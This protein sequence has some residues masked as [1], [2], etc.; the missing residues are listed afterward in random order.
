[1]SHQRMSKQQTVRGATR[2]NK[3]SQWQ[4]GVVSKDESQQ[5]QK[6]ATDHKKLTRR[7][8][9]VASKGILPL[10]DLTWQEL[11]K[12]NG[13]NMATALHRLAR[14][15]VDGE[16]APD[17][18][19][20]SHVLQ[21]VLSHPAF[22][23]LLSAVE[24]QATAARLSSFEE[25]EELMPAQCASILA[26]SLAAMDMRNLKLLQVLADL[27]IP[28]M[29]RF[30][31]YEVTNMLWAY[32]K[33]DAA[34]H[35]P[36][37][38]QVIAWRLQ[39]RSCGEFKAHSLA[40]ALWSFAK[41]KQQ[42]RALFESIGQELSIRVAEL[43]SQSLSNVCWAFAEQKLAHPALFEAVAWAAVKGKGFY[44]IKPAELTTI[45]RAYALCASK[46]TPVLPGFFAKAGAVAFELAE[47]MVPY[48][49]THIMQ[50]LA[51][52]MST[53][54]VCP[55]VG[56]RLLDVAADRIDLFTPDELGCLARS[57]LKVCP[58]HKAFFEASGAS[59]LKRLADFGARDLR[60]MI[61]AISQVEGLSLAV[62]VM[63][64]ELQARMPT[65]DSPAAVSLPEVTEQNQRQASPEGSQTASTSAPSAGSD[66]SDTEREQC[67]EQADERRMLHQS[68]FLAAS[69]VMPEDLALQEV[70]EVTVD[71]AFTQRAPLFDYKLFPPPG[72][73]PP[74]GLEACASNSSGHSSLCRDYPILSE[75]IKSAWSA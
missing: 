63:K 56:L 33:L 40:L 49:V 32:A 55:K 29:G 41:A 7:L 31:P 37:L 23:A 60:D 11:P 69:N 12:M 10:L 72:L 3:S 42:D 5:L 44:Q 24:M 71:K 65:K 9:E 45:L 75:G 39:N 67:S 25:A 1:M 59:S 46:G 17:A 6:D 50:S 70:P 16:T 66:A 51:M 64:T 27:G 54:Q 47:H 19:A 74:P 14:Y 18:A 52:A 34:S 62:L 43:R 30:Q 73:S 61:E 15:C 4:H 57:A 38:M 13:V 28:H 36:K 22:S 35:C 21:G 2:A 26:W 58:G 53:A 68:I 48:Q 8:T 20:S